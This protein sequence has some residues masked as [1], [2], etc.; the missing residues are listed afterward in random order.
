[1]DELCDFCRN[2][3]IEKRRYE[4]LTGKSQTVIEYFCYNCNKGKTVFIDG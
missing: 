1:M 3:M 4:I 2:K